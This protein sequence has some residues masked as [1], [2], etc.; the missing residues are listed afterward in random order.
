MA[1]DTQETDRPTD[2][3]PAGSDTSSLDVHDYNALYEK[4]KRLYEEEKSLLEQEQRTLL[5]I[6]TTKGIKPIEKI[7]LAWVVLEGATRTPDGKW[8]IPDHLTEAGIAKHVNLSK[9]TV[10][11]ALRALADA[12]IIERPQTH[13]EILRALTRDAPRTPRTG[14]R[15]RR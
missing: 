5:Q 4:E 12:G 2:H 13:S 15:R 6:V 1:A 14:G 10:S 9:G 11:A 8:V 3:P 7:V